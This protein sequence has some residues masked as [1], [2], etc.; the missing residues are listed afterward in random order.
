MIFKVLE[1]RYGDHRE[2]LTSWKSMTSRP[3][4]CHMD[5]ERIGLCGLRGC[6][7]TGEI[8]GV[9]PIPRAHKRGVQFR[10]LMSQEF[11][12]KWSGR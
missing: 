2:G 8:S 1:A 5:V 3:H 7:H 6:L 11:V 4:S 9:R 12:A 10:N